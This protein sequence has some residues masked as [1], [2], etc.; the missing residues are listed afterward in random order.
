M[1]RM[2]LLMA[3]GTVLFGAAARASAEAV[4]DEPAPAFSA[5]DLSG[6]NRTLDE[7]KGKFIVL[8][9]FNPECPFVKKHYDSGNMQRLQKAWTGKGAAWVTV[10][11]SASGKQGHV[12]AAQARDVL[13]KWNAAPTAFILDENGAV[14][15]Q[16]GAKT[17][18]HIYII[19]P[20][21]KLIYAGAIDDKPSA[22]KADIEGAVNYVDATLT[23]A[24]AGEPVSVS[25]TKPY[26]CS[27]KYN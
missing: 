22:D 6:A 8:E 27:V 13:A 14:G 26:G 2:A 12:T 16:Y 5:S 3:L 15:R 21:G 20:E 19:N 23:K 9:W 1:K 18:P 25:S 24:L 4:V 7:F 11:S 10:A 17:T